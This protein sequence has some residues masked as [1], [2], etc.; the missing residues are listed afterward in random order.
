MKILNLY[1][2]L[3]GNRALWGEDVEVTAVE[4]DS[5]IADLYKKRFPQDTVIVSD[6]HK[7]LIDHVHEFG[8]IWS[9]PPCQSHSR[10]R[11]AFEAHG[12]QNYIYPDLKLYEE[13]LFLKSFARCK[14]VVE[15]VVP[16]YRPLVKPSAIRGRHFFWSNFHIPSKGSLNSAKQPV[17]SIEGG[18]GQ[19]RYG[20]TAE[21]YKGKK[22]KRALLRNCVD[23]QIGKF[24]LDC[25][26]KQ[27]VL[28]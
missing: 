11:A 9:S 5:G 14:W 2:G 21:G 18:K 28:L 22:R 17:M 23:P 24:I 20:F 16:Y 27:Q 25:A 19:E 3:G 7:F 26:F 1:A 4:I 15:N 10:A 8:F 13:I 12:K 6:A